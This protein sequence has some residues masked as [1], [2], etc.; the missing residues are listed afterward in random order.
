MILEII[1]WEGLP[2]YRADYYI[3][4][5]N[6]WFYWCSEITF[7]IN[8]T[9]YSLIGECKLLRLSRHLSNIISN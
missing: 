4:L 5:I 3:F 6:L 9:I 1:G 7:S 2:S 8:Y